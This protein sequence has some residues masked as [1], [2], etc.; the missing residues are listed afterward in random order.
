MTQASPV[1]GIGK[2]DLNGVPVVSTRD[3]AELSNGHVAGKRR[4]DSFFEQSFPN[5]AHPVQTGAR[6]L[7]IASA[8]QLFSERLADMDG[9]VDRPGA[10]RIDTHRNRRTE[11]RPKLAY[12]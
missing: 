6:V 7:Q 12:R 11:L 5:R 3:I 1:V 10:I 9:R 2:H 4:C 8:G